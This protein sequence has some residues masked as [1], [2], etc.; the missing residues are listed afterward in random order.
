MRCTRQPWTTLERIVRDFG[1]RSIV[2]WIDVTQET[3]LT[4]SQRGNSYSVS[5]H[6]ACSYSTLHLMDSTVP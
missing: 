1:E 5:H 6:Y 2:E 3:G 4:S